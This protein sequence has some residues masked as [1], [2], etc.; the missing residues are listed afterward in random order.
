MSLRSIRLRLALAAVTT[1]V[2]AM[3]VVAALLIWL[4]DRH[5]RDRISEDLSHHMNQLV[6]LLSVGSNG[7]S[8]DGEMVD[9]RFDKPLGG[10]YWQVDK[11]ERPVLRSRSLWDEPLKL[12]LTHTPAHTELITM[13]GPGGH[14]LLGVT[15]T[16][17]LGQ[18]A[19]SFRL[20]V[21][22]D[23]EDLATA[24]QRMGTTLA[25]GLLT[26]LL[27]L[28]LAAWWQ[29]QYGLRPLDDVRGAIESVRDG[30]R[31]D[32][33]TVALP[34]E[35]QPLGREINDLVA[36]QTA[37]TE[38]AKAQSGNL[39][40]GLKTPLA[41]IA[42]EADRLRRASMPEIAEHLERHVA[43]MQRHV[44][45]HLALAR[46]QGGIRHAGPSRINL[47]ECLAESM[48]ALRNLPSDRAISWQL[49]GDL[50]TMAEIG[51]EDLEEVVGN[52]M[53]N[54]RKW[55]RSRI[56]V[57]AKRTGSGV[58]VS[59]SDDG[60]GISDDK[61]AIVRQRGVRLDER[62]P[63][64]GL[65]LSIAEAI[66]ETYRSEL[67]LGPAEFGGLEASFELRA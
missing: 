43:T 31:R 63:G 18:D 57:R 58:L 56:D 21:A 61:L 29:I 23:A 30:T 10:L 51:R 12:K 48:A 35:V 16:I 55:A 38:R 41:A 11:D 24:R 3:I 47:G 14:Q 6:A 8:L 50:D 17:S 28:L 65:G 42:A 64:S 33:D 53:D 66:L 5:V 19:T 67:R 26:V 27:F 45:R 7:P 52:L 46:S 4:F 54:A 37:A 32:I 36:A 2:A 13:S 40:H 25:A 59:V 44:E 1:L 34:D 39:A 62:V 15:R 9:P 60:A 20:V 49:S 22:V